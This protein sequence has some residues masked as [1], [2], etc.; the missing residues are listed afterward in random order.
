MDEPCAV[1][2]KVIGAPTASKYPMQENEELQQQ[3]EV[4][5][6]SNTSQRNIQEGILAGKLV[7]KISIITLL[8]VGVTELIIANLVGSASTFA[9]GMNL[10]SYVMASFNLFVGLYMTSY[11]ANGKFHFGYHKVESFVALMT[12]MG[13]VAM[14]LAIIYHSYMSSIYPYEIK[15]P[16]IT[17]VVL[18]LATAISFY[19]AF[20]IRFLA[21][22]YNILSLQTHAK[23]SIRASSVSTISLFSVLVAIQLGYLQMDAIGGLLIGG[24]IFY[25]AYVSLKKSSLN[26][27]DAW[28]NPKVVEKIR[29][30]I[31]ENKKFKEKVNVDSILLR[32]TGIT[33]AHAEIQ[34]GVDGYIPLTDVELLCIQIEMAIRSEISTMNRV[35]I[36][37]RARS[38][39]NQRIIEKRQRQLI[40]AH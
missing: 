25:I 21:N 4:V 10:L 27:V 8:G 23:S 40:D 38:T 18:S 17:V 12:A 2:A 30:I 22:K 26:L 36:I 13:M 6:D 11:P 35:S 34:I 24:Y 32:P 28:E 15:Q 7:A 16:L 3:Y 1:D 33:G 14:G 37:P 9:G 5:S 39:L 20:Q 19:S 31:Q 29:N